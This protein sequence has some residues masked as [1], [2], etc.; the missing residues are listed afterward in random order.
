M[1]ATE[2]L[3]QTL[4]ALPEGPREALAARLLARIE[5]EMESGTLGPAPYRTVAFEDIEHLL[6]TFEGP[7]DLSRNKAY[8]AGLGESSMR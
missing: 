3:Q 2:R 7:P 5:A 6:G 1:S 4:D 8:L